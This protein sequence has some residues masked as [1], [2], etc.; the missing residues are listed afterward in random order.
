MT[1]VKV[2]AHLQ[3]YVHALGEDLA[4]RFFLRFGGAPLYLAGRPQDRS[5]LIEFMSAEHVAALA[6]ALGPGHIFRVPINREWIANRLSAKGWK[7]LAIAREL[8]VTDVTVRKWLKPKDQRQ[9]S[10]F[11]KL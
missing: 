2:P 6:K 8:H 3:P 4:I 10:F 7:T 1:D 5:Q 9:L 11:S